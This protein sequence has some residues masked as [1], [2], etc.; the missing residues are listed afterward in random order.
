MFTGGEFV[1]YG[2]PFAAL[3]YIASRL[4][5]KRRIYSKHD[6]KSGRLRI[7]VPNGKQGREDF[8]AINEVLDEAEEGFGKRPIMRRDEG[9]KKITKYRRRKKKN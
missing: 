6:R 3:A 7:T 1:I 8:E 2:A 4:F 5:S 9:I